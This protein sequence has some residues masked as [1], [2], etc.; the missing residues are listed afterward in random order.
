MTLAVLCRELEIAQGSGKRDAASRLPARF[1][2]APVEA[3]V[4]LVSLVLNRGTAKSRNARSFR[5]NNRWPAY[6]RLIGDWRQ[7]RIS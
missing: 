2:F 5:G 1:H 4:V 3:A 6:M 7:V